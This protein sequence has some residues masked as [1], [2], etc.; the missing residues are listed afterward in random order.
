M[1]ARLESPQQIQDF[2]DIIPPNFEPHGDTLS[3]VSEA[4]RRRS[5]HCIEGAFI[6]AC[7]LMISGQ[8]P[9]LMDMQAEGDDDHVVV[10]FR[11][12]GCWGA[13]SKSNHVWL[14]WRDPV[15]RSLRELAMSYFHE[16]RNDRARLCLRTYSLPFDLRRFDSR[17]WITGKEPCWDVGCALDETRHYHLITVAQAERLRHSDSIEMRANDLSQVERPPK[18]RKS[19]QKQA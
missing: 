1:L 9:L 13:I 7:A 3:S 11:E 19:K 4:L 12:R 6:A 8:P 18:R 2:I 14:R 17:A 10:L 5:I 15:Y 16:Y